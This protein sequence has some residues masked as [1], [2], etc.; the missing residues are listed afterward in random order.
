MKEFFKIVDSLIQSNNISVLMLIV[1]VFVLYIFWKSGLIETF[2]NI[3]SNKEI[4]EKMDEF[5]DNIQNKIQKSNDDVLELVKESHKNLT[6]LKNMVDKELNGIKKELDNINDLSI[7]QVTDLKANLNIRLD[8][9][10]KTQNDINVKLAVINSVAN[11][12]NNNHP[13]TP[14]HGYWGN[15]PK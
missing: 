12:I 13:N 10:S 15:M 3:F 1:F 8:D 4:L 7:Q 2:K 11:N 14:Q 9:V 6:E 5:E